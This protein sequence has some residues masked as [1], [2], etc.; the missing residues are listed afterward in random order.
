MYLG[1]EWFDG[2]DKGSFLFKI[3]QNNLTIV[4]VFTLFK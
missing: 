1:L 2:V 4:N 3:F